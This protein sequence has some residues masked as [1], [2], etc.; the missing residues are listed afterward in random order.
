MA[1]IGKF[2]GVNKTGFS[3]VD[4]VLATNIAGIDNTNLVLTTP[5]QSGDVVKLFNYYNFRGE[6]TAESH[7]TNSTWR[8]SSRM[9]NQKPT[10]L[11]TN[12]DSQAYVVWRNHNT[13]TDIYYDP[14]NGTINP[15]G[16]LVRLITTTSDFSSIPEALQLR[17]DWI[18]TV[19]EN[20][21][22]WGLASGATPSNNTGPSGGASG[23]YLNDDNSIFESEIT[24][25][26]SFNNIPFTNPNLNPGVIVSDSNNKYIYAETTTS[27]AD[28]IFVCCF[29][30]SNIVL[31]M[32]NSNNDLKLKFM[33]HAYGEDM[34]KLF[35][36][37]QSSLDYAINDGVDPF[38]ETFPRL[39][40]DDD[41]NAPSDVRALTELAYYSS[42]TLKQQTSDGVAYTER[43]ISLNDLKT[44]EGGII[45]K[46]SH[47]IYFVYGNH[48][49][50]RSDL[51][52]DNIR[53]EEVL[54]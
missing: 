33:T 44:I 25:L 16:A 1:P 5:P 8:P 28:D 26:S 41:D 37:Y 9:F 19:D 30:I 34:G 20:I 18:N 43:E 35:V 40:G 39:Y 13:P 48:T 27:D 17:F 29:N 23:P 52:I 14:N 24:D 11:Y 49:G 32:F 6:T 50:Y 46:R 3:R 54:P 42:T 12:L 47:W 21:K 51:S 53:I 36:G 31:R 7:A 45:S 10:H 38:A 4:D 15:G 2:S 22:G